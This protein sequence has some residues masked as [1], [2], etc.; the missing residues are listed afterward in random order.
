MSRARSPAARA[1]S[2]GFK[3]GEK[4]LIYHPG[5]LE[6]IEANGEIERYV[7]GNVKRVITIRN[8]GNGFVGT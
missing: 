4:R 6:L 7:L 8:G 2:M 1:R 5:Q 3:V